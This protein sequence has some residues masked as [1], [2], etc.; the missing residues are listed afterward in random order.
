[1]PNNFTI[2]HNRFVGIKYYLR[3]L[4][5]ELNQPFT[6][7][8]FRFLLFQNCVTANE[9]YL[10]LHI[11]DKPHTAFQWRVFFGDIVTIVDKLLFDAAS[12]ECVH[13]C[14]FQPVV[15]TLI[16]QKIE[17]MP[18]LV[19]RHVKLPAQFA[20]IRNTRCISP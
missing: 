1:M 10:F 9:R 12:V 20:D 4:E 5:Q 16:P 8:R 6:H 15:L 7:K 17:S 13:A 11:T 2:A 19:D 3:V 14:H 18:R